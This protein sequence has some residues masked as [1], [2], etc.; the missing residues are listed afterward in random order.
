MD[1]GLGILTFGTLGFA[2]AFGYVS[3]R[4]TEKLRKS[5]APK[6]SLSRDGMAERLAADTQTTA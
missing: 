4:A 3:A 5:D 2:V 1:F 6:S